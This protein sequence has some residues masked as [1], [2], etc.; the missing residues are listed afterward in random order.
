MDTYRYSEWDGT[1]D[2]FEPDADALMDELER[3]LMSYG[4]LSDALRLLQRGGI[5]DRQGRRLP[6]IQ[7]LLKQLRQRRQ[8]QDSNRT[9]G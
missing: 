9:A 1:Q 4:D 6:S 8:N 5:R 2:L 7:D 3:N